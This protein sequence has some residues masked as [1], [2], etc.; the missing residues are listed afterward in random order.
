MSFW[1]WLFPKEKDFYKMLESQSKVTLK[2]IEA[3]S[4]Y[5]HRER[6][7]TEQIISDIEHEADEIRRLL[8]DDINKTFITPIERQ[9][10]FGLSRVVDDFIDLAKSAVEEFNIYS[11]EP[12]EHLE[13]MGLIIRDGVKQIDIAISLL[14]EHPSISI[15]RC[16]SAKDIVDDGSILYYT[17]LKEL[18]ESEDIKY[19]FKMREIYKHMLEINNK[20]SEAANII[21]DIIVKSA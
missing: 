15:E 3:F 9:D 16:I 17:A 7:S 2:G 21:L 11:L 8:I 18:A 13:N 19:M 12:N 14:K 5:M 10:L 1:S 4:D 20:I 6:S